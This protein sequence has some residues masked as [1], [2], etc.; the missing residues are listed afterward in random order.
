MRARSTGRTN[1]VNR[2]RKCLLDAA[3][4]LLRRGAHPSLEEVAAEALVSRATAYRHFPDVN[5]LLLEASF[6]ID[7]PRKE[8]LFREGLAN[9]P[10]S[11]LQRVDAALHDMTLNNERALRIMLARTIERRTSQAADGKVPVRQNRRMPLIEEALAPARDQFTPA[12][13]KTLAQA[14][15]LL[16]GPEALVVFKDVLN[17]EDAVARRV[18]RWAIKALVEAAM[19]P[20]PAR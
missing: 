12:A 1:Q 9:D 19:K 3:A 2:T 13:L 17:V 10:V 18:K 8:D 11:R 16:V 6:D 4:A 20:S 15:A 14:L 7:T 5:T